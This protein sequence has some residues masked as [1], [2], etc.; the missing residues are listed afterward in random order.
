WIL[1]DFGVLVGGGAT[2]TIYPSNTPEECRYI[3][4]DSA[5]TIVFAEDDDQVKKILEVRGQLPSLTKVITFDGKADGDGFVIT[6]DDLEALG[7]TYA[8]EHPNAVDERVAQLTK[9]HLATLI[10]TSGTTGT[11]KGVEL[12]HDCWV[13]EAEGVSNIGILSPADHQYLWLPLSHSF[14]KVLQVVQLMVG[15]STT[16][17]GRIPKLVDNLAVIKPTFMAAAPRIFEK[18]YNK[19][20]TGAQQGGGLKWKIFS[21]S[22]G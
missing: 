1:A 15:F 9:D 7:K 4:S 10:Y 3:L 6:L 12:T 8:K 22:V 17:D 13:F 21:W 19:V 14:G 5:T 16:V 2:T 20:V 18:V 11:P